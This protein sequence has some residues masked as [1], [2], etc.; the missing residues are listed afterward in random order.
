M[1]A[2]ERVPA[3]RWDVVDHA[4]TRRALLQ[5]LRAGRRSR[6]EVCDASPFLVR[7]ARE[8]GT[9]TARACPVCAA[10]P[11]REIA[12]V[13]GDALGDGS[14]TA[15]SARGVALLAASRPGFDVYELEVCLSCDWNHLVRTYSTG[16][17]GTSPAPRS[18]ERRER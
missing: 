14:G 13:Y 18:R 8:W 9:R 5:D 17:P 12:W 15:R 1:T 16:T 11:V 6:V 3:R 4:L 2:A 7:A 10:A